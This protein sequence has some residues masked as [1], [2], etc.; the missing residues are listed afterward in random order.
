MEFKRVIL[1]LDFASSDE[2]SNFVG[3]LFD[4]IAM[5]KIGLQMF[6]TEGPEAVEK[7]TDDIP[8]FLDLKLHDIPET[9]G[10][11]VRSASRLGVNY[12]TVHAAGGGEML[13]RAVG[14]AGP[15]TDIVAVT[16][17]TSLDR[18]DLTTIG[19]APKLDVTSYA[20]RLAVLAYTHGVRTFVCSPHEVEAIRVA[21]GDDVML[22]VPGIRPGE[23]SDD[24]KR[25][26]TPTSAIKAGADF[27]IIGRPIY[28]AKDPRAMIESINEEID[29]ALAKE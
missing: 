2:A 24:Q 4:Q 11:A 12:L 28:T 5:V 26:A 18:D 29:Q 21:L 20:I 19:V 23:P 13:K 14:E 15:H 1:P 7:F 16:A 10:R 25:I 6:V 27:L 3:P 22:L 8:V 9:V 17:L